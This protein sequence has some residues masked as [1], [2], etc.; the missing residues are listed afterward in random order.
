MFGTN[1]AHRATEVEIRPERGARLVRRFANTPTYSTRRVCNRRPDSE[2]GR[3]RSGLRTSYGVLAKT[4]PVAAL[5]LVQHPPLK[6]S[7]LLLQRA[8][9]SDVGYC[10]RD[11]KLI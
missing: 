5:N 4:A 6:Q 8:E 1:S 9:C 11:A 10:E 7:F 3:S 2:P